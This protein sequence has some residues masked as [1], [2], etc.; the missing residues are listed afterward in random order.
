MI[1]SIS[2]AAII[3][4][5]FN[6]LAATSPQCPGEEGYYF[7]N[8]KRRNPTQGGFV[9]NKADVQDTDEMIF[10][11][12]EVAICGSSRVSG[13]ARIFG[14]SVIR[15]AT[16]KDSA[17]ISEDAVVSSGAE[18]S[19]NAKV[20]GK[21]VVSGFVEVMEDA[22][23][24]DNASVVNSD[25]ERLARVSGKARV[26]GSARVTE[27]AV[28]EG[29]ARVNGNAKLYGNVRVDGSSLIKGHTKRSSGKISGETLND[30]DYEGIEKARKE[31]EAYEE[32]CRQEEEAKKLAK[33][34]ADIK[35]ALEAKQA[36]DAKNAKVIDARNEL[37]ALGVLT[38]YKVVF[39][40]DNCLM[41][42]TE[43]GTSTAI[44]FLLSRNTNSWDRTSGKSGATINKKGDDKAQLTFESE[45]VDKKNVYVSFE[46]SPSNLRKYKEAFDT[47]YEYCKERL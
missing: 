10:I 45:F 11:G 9:S 1:K 15:S 27:D 3:L 32:K 4:F 44:P 29:S 30:P 36:S 28:V 40:D 39:K 24:T 25:S 17:E 34:A 7:T 6:S 41:E 12:P 31:R 5:S 38:G 8:Y 23:V 13:R 46:G 47:L 26:G 43:N 33:Q 2:A 37:I 19:G 14:S 35:A 20:S 16:V 22:V 18:V 21:A 42:M